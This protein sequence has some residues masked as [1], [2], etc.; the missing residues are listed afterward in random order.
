[1]TVDYYRA[2]PFVKFM[3]L[4]NKLQTV[5]A[6]KTGGLLSAFMQRASNRT[7]G[8]LITSPKREKEVMRLLILTFSVSACIWFLHGIFPLVLMSYL[9]IPVGSDCLDNAVFPGTFPR[10]GQS[11]GRYGPS[12][13]RPRSSRNK[14]GALV[15]W[16]IPEAHAPTSNQIQLQ[17][18]C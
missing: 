4:S 13:F 3:I 8:F 6:K 7:T 9:G 17:R 1:M 16:Y 10:I 11:S 14:T 15:A 12:G 2:P 18:P 5:R